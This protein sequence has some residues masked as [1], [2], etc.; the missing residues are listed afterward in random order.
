MCHERC[1]LRNQTGFERAEGA[2]DTQPDDGAVSRFPFVVWRR[3][4][5]NVCNSQFGSHVMELVLESNRCLRQHPP[6]NEL[7]GDPYLSLISLF[8]LNAI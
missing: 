8:N 6:P 2:A 4:I 1:S 5:V 7:L 3:K